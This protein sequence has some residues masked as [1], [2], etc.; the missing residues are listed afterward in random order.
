MSGQSIPRFYAVIPAGGVGSRLWPLSRADHPK[1]L[2]DLSGNGHTLLRNTWNRL[3]PLV[4]QGQ[5]LVVTGVSHESA[6]RQ[7]LPELEASNLIA[8][9][10]PKDS[11]SAIGLAAL[12]VLR[13]DPEAIVGSFAADH[14]ISDDTVFQQAVREAVAAAETGALVTIGIRPSEPSSAFG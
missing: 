2:H 11:A 10:S 6:V 13:R 3:E 4:D 1:F 7:Q 9:P 14:V 12:I 8:E 5:L